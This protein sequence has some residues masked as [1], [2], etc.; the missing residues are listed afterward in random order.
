MH[1]IKGFAYL[2]NKYWGEDQA[3]VVLGFTAPS[4]E[5][6]S[7]FTF[8]SM[9]PVE[10]RA[11]TDNMREYF[12]S[13]TDDHFV[14]M[15]DDYWLTEKIDLDE[16]AEM[17]TL[18]I[19]GA[20]KADLSNNTNHFS[21]TTRGEYVVADIPTHYRT[22]TQPA[23]WSREWLIGIL[24]PRL[25]PWEFELQGPSKEL[26]SG[27]LIGKPRHIFDFANVY[28][29]GAPAEYMI[30]RLSAADKNALIEL[31]AFDKFEGYTP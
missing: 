17:E 22:S 13:I 14:F 5:L 15:F 10:T 30:D 7:N 16:V 21:H 23:V 26:N 25:N 28:Y 3:V 9:E 29:K 8:H 18:V 31:N 19:E 4:F 20:V 27:D 12:A 24:K 6:P 2:F 1:L 11:W